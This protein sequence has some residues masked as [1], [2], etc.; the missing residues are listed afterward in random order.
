MKANLYSHQKKDTVDYSL[1]LLYKEVLDS[2]V[3][4]RKPCDKALVAEKL[5]ELVDGA[6]DPTMILK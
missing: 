4:Q 3:E 6:L 5:A 1:L 2:K